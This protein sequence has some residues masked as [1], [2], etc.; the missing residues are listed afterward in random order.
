M[1]IKS[2]SN[3][4]S[5]TELWL[6]NTEYENV[7]VKETTSKCKNLIFSWRIQSATK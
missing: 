7:T 1:K 2:F 4:L 5:S 6:Y 3:N